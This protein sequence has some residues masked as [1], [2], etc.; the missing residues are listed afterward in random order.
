MLQRR[1][2]E[3][4]SLFVRIPIFLALPVYLIPKL[5]V[6]AGGLLYVVVVAV[7][8]KDPTEKTQLVINWRAFSGILGL[9]F[10]LLVVV[11]SAFV[12]FLYPDLLFKVPTS[13]PLLWLGILLV[14]SILSVYPQELLYRSFFFKR[15][16][17]LF[18]S[19][20]MLIFIN[21]ILFSLAHL[22][23]GNLLVLL[24]TF[25]GGLVF[26]FT[27]YRTNSMLLVSIE[28]ALYG[29]WLFT[30]GMGDMLGFPS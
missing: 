6:G 7:G 18:E 13:K 19:K 28:H 26:A 20:N 3:L 30:I 29:C 16:R 2:Y 24:L 22:F 12:Y 15:Y 23:F 8:T 25:I 27:Y 5:L 21:A 11:S 17:G 9:R 1:S 4:I 10:A 14:Y